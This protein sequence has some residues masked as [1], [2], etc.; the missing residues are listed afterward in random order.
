[1]AQKK[2]HTL[3]SVRASL[4]R[5][6]DIKF[7]PIGSFIVRQPS[8]DEEA[9]DLGN[10]SWGKIDYLQKVHGATMIRMGTIAFSKFKGVF[11]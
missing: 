2:R 8:R 1:M 5:K 7:D 9:I 11:Y 3:Q 4:Q 10:K 6:R